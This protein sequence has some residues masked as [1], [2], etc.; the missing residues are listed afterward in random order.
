MLTPAL[1][2][3]DAGTQQTAQQFI[4][5]FEGKND[6]LSFC[7]KLLEGNPNQP[8]V[9]FTLGTALDAAGKPAEAAD[10]FQKVVEMKPDYE[11]AWFR[12]GNAFFNQQKW[13]EA[14][15]AY[16]K[17]LDRT[18]QNE[19]AWMMYGYAFWKAGKLD[20]A[21]KAFADGLKVNPKNLSLLSNDAEL[22]FVQGDSERCQNRIAAALPL[23]QSGS[24]LFA[25][26]P[27]YQWLSNPTQGLNQV[28]TAIEQ[29][30]PAVKFTWSFDTS[31]PA[32]ERMDAKTQQAAQ[33]FIAFFEGKIDL[34]TLKAR[35]EQTP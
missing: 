30:D 25:L 6:L 21:A 27:F 11:N 33:E 31:K 2:R 17:Q 4:A 19:S 24:E 26:L 12:L 15:N 18:P 9:W 22:A 23:V 8:R 29:L 10:A 32:L 34:P 14:I 16:K 20:E 3:L 35:L 5:L 13:D 1:N 7:Q 28:L